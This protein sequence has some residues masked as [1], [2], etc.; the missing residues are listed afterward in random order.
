MLVALNMVKGIG[1]VLFRRLL[2]AFGSLDALRKATAKQ[3]QSVQGIGPILAGE[4]A[5]IRDK[6]KY[7]KELD[8]VARAGARIVAYSS[9]EY[10]VLLKTVFD[11]P[12]LMYVKGA[13]PE[14]G[15]PCI[16]VVGSR[17]PTF[18]GQQQAEKLSAA[19]AGRGACVISG[20]ARGI[21][22]HAHQGALRAKGATCGVLGSG[23][24]KIYPDENRKLAE[25]M[26]EHGAIISE[27]P[28]SSPP[29]ARNFPRR[30]RIVSGMSLGVLVVEAGERS[31][32]L[33]TADWAL[34]QNREVFAVPGKID[35]PQS[36]G[37]HNLIKRG[38]KLVQDVEDVLEELRGFASFRGPDGADAV[39]RPAPPGL[40]PAEE[41]LLSLLSSDPKPID[42]LIS[43]S[44]LTPGT[45]SAKLLSLELR[46]L[47]KQ[48]PGKNFVRLD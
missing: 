32:A 22:T 42:D 45:V 8:L 37:C 47:A 36:I 20:L 16:A 23:L 11:H 19:L 26:C 38:A 4:F 30:N 27:M 46:K 13:L 24:L 28:M 21:D 12:L 9:D 14:A 5:E 34:E 25:R 2:K 48:L 43:E 10:P 7:L 41:L 18:Y 40:S 39:K 33:I 44:Q 35:S 3:M 15:M 17:R 31:G 6:G 29:D 1:T